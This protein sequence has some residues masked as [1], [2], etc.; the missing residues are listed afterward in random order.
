MQRYDQITIRNITD[1]IDKECSNR[2]GSVFSN[3]EIKENIA[4]RK[5]AVLF[6]TEK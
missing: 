3:R 6:Y 4:M 5:C 1:D 2:N